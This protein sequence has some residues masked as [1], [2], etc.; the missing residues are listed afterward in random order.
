MA[1]LGMLLNLTLRARLARVTPARAGL[2]QHLTA[3]APGVLR[4]AA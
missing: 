1:A 4:A 2:F 3:I